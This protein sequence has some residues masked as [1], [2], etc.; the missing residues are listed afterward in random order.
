MS[1]SHRNI[2]NSAIVEMAVVL[3]ASAMA[4]NYSKYA[5][6]QGLAAQLLE[7]ELQAAVEA[8][9]TTLPLDCKTLRVMDLG[10]SD[11][12]NTGS[13]VE[14]LIRCVS[15]CPRVTDVELGLLDLPDNNWSVLANTAALWVQRAASAGLRLH[16][17]MI[18]QSFY[19][20]LAPPGSIDVLYACTAL[21]WSAGTGD[22]VGEL[23]TI[24]RRVSDAL[25]P[26]GVFVATTPTTV[27]STTP[28]SPPLR[29]WWQ[30]DLKAAA[31]VPGY[32]ALMPA[33][34]RTLHSWPESTWRSR[35]QEAAATMKVDTLRFIDIDDLYWRDA[36]SGAEYA[37]DHTASVEV[38]LHS[39]LQK[40]D[41]ATRIEVLNRIEMSA[42][43]AYDAT[44]P[45][46]PCP[47]DGCSVIV[48]A[49]RL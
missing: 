48:R 33:I 34:I 9:L 21:H 13:I 8:S 41:A 16:I 20:A 26:G 49:T 39:F 6:T 3:T 5:R 2:D 47:P 28:G 29:R 30:R 35:L 11:G 14:V 31:T 36:H 38:V 7:P 4:S 45:G 12:I 22:A 25:R 24:L 32:A 15:G 40:L 10:V 17:R 19:E 42:R 43:E 46:A 23:D 27:P 1:P 37:R 44:P 18:P